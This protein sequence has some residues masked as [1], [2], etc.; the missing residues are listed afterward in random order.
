M[1]F[2]SHVVVES[3]LR[4]LVFYGLISHIHTRTGARVCGVCES[5]IVNALVVLKLEFNYMY[6]VFNE[7]IYRT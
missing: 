7:D 1:V 2:Y 4:D 3:G 6:E 5:R